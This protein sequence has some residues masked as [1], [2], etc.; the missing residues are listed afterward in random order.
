MRVVRLN[1]GVNELE[2]RPASRRG[3][4]PARGRATRSS[5]LPGLRWVPV[6]LA[7]LAAVIGALVMGSFQG[8]VASANAHETGYREGGL[9]LSVET[10]QWMM[11]MSPSTG[12]QMPGSMMEGFQK[13][14]DD[15]LRVEVNLSN[16]TTSVQPYSIGD[17]TISGRG[18]KTYHLDSMVHSNTPVS[19]DLAPGF[20]TNIDIYFDIPSQQSKHLILRWS[21]GGTTVSI[22]VNTN[23]SATTMKM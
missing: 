15:R 6:P 14:G 5:R 11:N 3:R 21:H 9:A 13:V 7:V 22:P 1:T 12:Y 20:G 17:F 10:M 2:P 19:A 8:Q 16:V 23:S 4:R 18:G